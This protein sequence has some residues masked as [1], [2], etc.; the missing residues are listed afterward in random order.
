MGKSTHAQNLL[1]ASEARF[2]TT[3]WTAVLASQSDS[4]HADEA[5]ERLCHSYWRPLYAYVRRRG[6]SPEEAQDLTQ[7]FFA[8]LLKR[9]DLAR[10]KPALGRFRSFLLASL[11]HFLSNRWNAAQ[12]QKRGGG[13]PL[14]SWD[15]EALE[16]QYEL[17]TA[18][19][20]T[21]DILFERRWALA[22]L[23]Q[24]LEQLAR[25]HAHAGKQELFETLKIFLSG[26]RNQVPQEEIAVKL[27]IT[28]SAVRVAVHRLRQRYGQALRE[29][30]ATTVSSSAEIEDEIRYLMAVLGR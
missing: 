23:E 13:K 2:A 9:N 11:K 27:G 6:Y 28:V 15:D 24:A 25:E 18:D 21:P 5:L 30:I 22:V 14:L 4:P 16:R 1:P 3:H 19:Q 20:P 26:D 8:Q 29:Q 10:V 12:T 7:E 17:E